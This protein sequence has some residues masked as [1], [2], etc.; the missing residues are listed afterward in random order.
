MDLQ[1]LTLAA[2]VKTNPL[3][4]TIGMFINCRTQVILKSACLALELN[5]T[6]NPRK[7]CTL[8][9]KWNIRKKKGLPKQKINA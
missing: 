2:T 4:L 1:F 6:Y 5:T 7:L 9:K 8:Q 3:I